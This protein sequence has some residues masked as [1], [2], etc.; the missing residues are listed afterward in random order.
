ML[1]DVFGKAISYFPTDDTSVEKGVLATMEDH[2]WYAQR[3]RE[4]LTNL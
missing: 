2:E 1:T 3:I 4:K